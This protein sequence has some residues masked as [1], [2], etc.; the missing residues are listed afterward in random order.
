[1]C[2][3][4]GLANRSRSDQP[5]LDGAAILAS[6]RHRGP[7][8]SG[9]AQIEGGGLRCSF[10]QTRLSIL[11]LSPAGHQPMATADGRYWVV[12]NGEIYNHAA[13]RAELEMCGA[14]FRSRCDTEVVTWFRIQ[15]SLLIRAAAWVA[16][17]WSRQLSRSSSRSTVLECP[18]I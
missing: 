9:S 14:H 2:G 3:I 16:D 1:M 12:F 5:P 13:L 7:D 6:L 4:F 8:D 11:D 18:L 10:H 15:S 17:S